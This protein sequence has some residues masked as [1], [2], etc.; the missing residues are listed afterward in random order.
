[1]HVH[2]GGPG[3]FYEDWSKFDPEKSSERELESYLYCGITAVRSAGDRLDDMLKLRARFD[4]GEKL[5]TELFFAVRSLP[6][7]ADTARNTRRICRRWRAPDSTRSLSARRR[8]RR[9]AQRWTT[10]RHKGVNAIKGILEAGV[11]GYTFNRMDVDMLRA[12]VDEAHAQNL[13]VSI[14]TGDARDVVDA[15]S[16][17]ADSV[18]HGSFRDE[19]PDATIA[20]MKAKGIAYD[21]TL[22]VVEGLTTLRKGRRSCSSVR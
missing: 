3:G 4:S 22:S 9:S 5:G 8:R 17:G 6:P 7:K 12:V 16:L 2:L 1:M 21:P 14:H 20:E 13:P 18:E 11:P 19:I 10:S 15:V